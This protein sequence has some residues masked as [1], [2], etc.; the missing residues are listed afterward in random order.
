ME[1]DVQKTSE[2]C[3]VPVIWAFGNR[4]DR[5]HGIVEDALAGEFA[6]TC[7]QY[8]H[9]LELSA[10]GSPAAK[11]ALVVVSGGVQRDYVAEVGAA[12]NRLSWAL[13]L[14]TADEQT[15]FDW[16]QLRGSNR[17]IWIQMPCGDK[18][19]GCDRVFPIG[20]PRGTRQM[21]RTLQP[22]CPG[23]ARRYPWSFLGQMQH[24][25]RRDCIE[26]LGW[27]KDGGKVTRTAGFAQGY[28]KAEYLRL[29]TDSYIAPGPA[30]MYTTDC[31]RFWEALECGCLPVVDKRHFAQPAE[32]D[33]WIDLLGGAWSP[34]PIIR[35]NWREFNQIA[36]AYGADPVKRQ[37]DT[38][39]AV[40]WWITYKQEF[41]RQL[42][43]D[44]AALSGA[45]LAPVTLKP[46]PLH[47]A[48]H[49]AK[50]RILFSCNWDKAWLGCVP[51]MGN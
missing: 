32:Y 12:V 19:K 15:E 7:Y 5:C 1:L 36:D 47:P 46:V 33:Y 34:F 41:I 44:I 14:I 20:Y 9:H 11:G 27:R 45:E 22:E 17:K 38:N 48:N 37:R 49:E 16:R 35:N 24:Q 26:T 21:L 10:A 3:A 39:A 51:V 31:F 50:R 25:Q 4:D 43:G 6:P 18:T 8:S 30:G 40:L 42:E 29:L 2:I 13:I 23:A 28:D